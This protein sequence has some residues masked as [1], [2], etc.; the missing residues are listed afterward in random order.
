M[1]Y[2]SRCFTRT[3]VLSL[4]K[5]VNVNIAQAYYKVSITIAGSLLFMLNYN[6]EREVIHRGCFILM[7]R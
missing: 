7:L 6:G 1:S 2:L 4:R 5:H 3:I